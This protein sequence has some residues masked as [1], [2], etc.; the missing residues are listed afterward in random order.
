MTQQWQN[1]HPT[2]L[3]FW[4]GDVV[5]STFYVSKNVVPT[6]DKNIA[7]FLAAI[8]AIYI[9]SSLTHWL[10]P[11]AKLGQSYTTKGRP[12]IETWGLHILWPV[13]CLRGHF[14]NHHKLYINN[15]DIKDINNNNNNN[16]DD[17]DNNDNDDND[18]NDAKKNNNEV[19]GISALALNR[20]LGFS[21]WWRQ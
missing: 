19:E 6:P 18:N 8:A 13:V 21:R 4:D 12:H 11:G 15:D 5:F 9:G 3:K 10:R 14:R 1:M 2:F 16:D 7:T 20:D 17:G